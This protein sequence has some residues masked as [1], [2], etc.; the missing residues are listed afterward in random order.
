MDG[1]TLCKKR[2]SY[3]APAQIPVILASGQSP[4]QDD[5]ALWT[6]FLGKPVDLDLLE[7]NVD[8]LLATR[9]RHAPNRPH[10]GWRMSA[11]YDPRLS[12]TERNLL[13]RLGAAV[14]MLKHHRRSTVVGKASGLSRIPERG[15]STGRVGRR[16]PNARE[17]CVD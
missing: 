10:A 9:L 14:E 1:V 6:L 7:R 5:G 15:T 4:P 11:P 2:Q 8:A 16:G 3:P 13:G 17:Y 12:T